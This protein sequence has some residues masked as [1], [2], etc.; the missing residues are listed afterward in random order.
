MINQLIDSGITFA[1]PDVQETTFSLDAVARFVCNTLD[2]AVAAQASGEFDI[3]IIGSGMYGAYAAAKIFERAK[4]LN[5]PHRPRVLVLEGGPFLISEHFQNLTRMGA[6]FNLVN[7]PIVDENQSYLTQID[8]TSGD[9]Q[10]M[11]PHHR[12]VGGKSLFWGGWAPPLGN[13]DPEDDL[14]RWPKE[15]RDFLL[16]PDGYSKI[17]RQIGTEPTADYVQGELTDALLQKAGQ[18]VAAGTVPTLVR[19]VNAPIAVQA[20]TPESGLFSM[21]KFSSLPLLLDSVREDAEDGGQFN[22]SRNLFVVPHAQ[23]LRLETDQGRVKE[24]VILERKPSQNPE[25]PGLMQ[26]VVRLKLNGAAMVVLAGNTINSTRLALNSFPTPPLLGPERMGKNL[27]G[28]VRGNYYWRIRQSTLGLQTLHKFSTSALH[29][30][31]RLDVSEIQKKGRF[32][33][34]FYALGTTGAEPEEFLYR[35]IP[36]IED[37]DDVRAAVQATNMDQWIVIGIRTCGEMFGDPEADPGQRTSSFISVNPFG[38]AGDDLFLEPDGRE[39]RVPKVFVALIQRPEDARVR[40]VQTEAAFAFAAALANKTPA[41]A[42]LNTGGEFQFIRGGE[43][44]VGTT[45]HESGTLW[46]GE[47]P[48]KSVTD[49]HGHFHHVTNA[50]CVDQ[51]IFPAVGSSNPVPTGLALSG[52]VSDYLLKRFISVPIAPLEAGFTP[53]FDGSLNGWSKLG[54]GTIQALPGLGII[55]CG[56]AGVESDLGFIHTTKKYQDFVLRLDWKAFSIQANSGIFLHMPELQNND[57]NQLYAASLEVQI[58]ETGLDYEPNRNP[59]RVYGSS[60]HKTGAVY[61]RAPATRWAAKAV[62]RRGEEGYW[63][64]FEIT[65]SGGKITVVLNGENVVDQADLPAPLQAAG[66]IALQCH[67]DVVQFRNVRLREL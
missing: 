63:N 3:V 51:A 64:S 5:L 53:L 62:S 38:G 24:I 8:R 4:R 26:K 41:E 14:A 32:H 52:M 18:I 65:V 1:G 19:A 25:R 22:Q 66:F 23:V 34:Q 9:L 31:G 55:E 16:S 54:G 40:R 36:N 20:D 49:V 43:D 45:Y 58:D 10:G 15:V 2:E 21:D 42:H 44:G 30:E 17:A 39:L 57:F 50:F 11:S 13:L 7:Q 61:K 59:Q 67:T 47:H 33:F 37:L 60:L 29:V 6:F 56:T 12:C 35:L 46:M 27:M 28:H 48:D